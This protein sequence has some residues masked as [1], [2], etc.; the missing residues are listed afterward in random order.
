MV[1][2]DQAA[3]HR[4]PTRILR[5]VS[6]RR[7]IQLGWFT[8]RA[9]VVSLILLMTA[10]PARSAPSCDPSGAQTW[11]S[12]EE[13][14]ALGRETDLVLMDEMRM[15]CGIG[16]F[17]PHS[18]LA[19]VEFGWR[20]LKH[21]EIA[22]AYE[23]LA[24]APGP[25]KIHEIALEINAV[26]APLGFLTV[27]DGNKIEEDFLLGATTTRY[28]NEMEISREMRWEGFQ[29]A[30][31]AVEELKYDL[32]QRGWD[33]TR[34]ELGASKR[35]SKK[36]AIQIYFARQNGDHLSPGAFNAIG[37]QFNTNY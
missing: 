26:D 7:N 5:S 2:E 11:T 23:F 27:Q 19:K 22:P 35:L 12:I 30:P 31:F 8:V 15:N 24:I 29:F 1:S 6:N 37:I 28:T 10:V 33:Y 9:V 32:H 20:P 21:W 4:P 36:V 34:L 17:H 3:A 13:H 14:H 18:N 16:G 25:K